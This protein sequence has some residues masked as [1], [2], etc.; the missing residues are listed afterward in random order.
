MIVIVI[1]HQEIGKTAERKLFYFIIFIEERKMENM[2]TGHWKKLLTASV[3]ASLLP[4]GG[5]AVC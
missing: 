1:S 4:G 5:G 2:R 3:L